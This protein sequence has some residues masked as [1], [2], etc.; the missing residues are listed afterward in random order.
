MVVVD[1]SADL[2]EVVL[3]LGPGRG[4]ADLLDRGKQ[5]PHQH[6]DDR[7]HHQEFDQREG[8]SA[9]ADSHVSEPR[10]LRATLA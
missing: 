3:A 8:R 4:L 6:G 7:D 9:I 1:G 5:E 2:L 10:S